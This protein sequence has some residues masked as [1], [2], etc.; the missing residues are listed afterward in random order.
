MDLNEPSFYNYCPT[1]LLVHEQ[2][3]LGFE[4]V[5]ESHKFQQP[6]SPF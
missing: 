3:L 6:Y 4:A 5:H 1:L 2:P